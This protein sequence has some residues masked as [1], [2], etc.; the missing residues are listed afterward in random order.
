MKRIYSQFAYGPGPRETC[1]WDETI[2]APDWSVLQGDLSVDVAIVGGGFTGMSAALHLVEAGAT[3]AVLEAETPGFGASGRNGGFCCLGGAKLSEAGFI[4]SFGKPAAAEFDRAEVDAIDLVAGLL[5]RLGIDADRHSNG[6][7]QLAH[8]AKDMERFRVAAGGNSEL[9]LI[10][11]ADLAV[12][13]L[14]GPFFGAL[15]TPVGFG[16]NPRKYLFGLAAAARAAGASL[17]QNSAVLLIEQHKA[18]HLVKTAKGQVR[19][20]KVLIATN[21]YSS[22]DLPEW[23]AGRYMPTQST[24]LVTRPLSDEELAAQGWTSVQM[25]YDTRNLLHYFRL[26]PD[27]RFLFGNRGGLMCSPAS[28]QRARQ[29]TRRDFERMFPAWRDVPS[30]HSWSGMVCLS[31]NQV[32]FAGPVPGRP[33]IFA[34]FAYHGNGVAMGSYTGRMLAGLTGGV[35]A[36]IPKAM[37]CPAGRFP[38]GRARR[39]LIPPIYAA[40]GLRDV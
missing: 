1:W 25:S 11:A 2:A 10:E 39:V 35:D 28:E 5:D 30:D 20:D 14:N 31:R 19:C 18:G 6:E 32:P 16:L 8:R 3:V 7:T 15:T 36:P 29:R 27:R 4:R 37:Q 23:M 33:G 17:F 22:D 34:G 13:G 12:H 38:L 24:I 26:M 40:M 9:T 21:G